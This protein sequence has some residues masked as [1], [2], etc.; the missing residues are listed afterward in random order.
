M[1]ACL[2]DSSALVACLLDEPGGNLEGGSLSQGA[3]ASTL[4]VQEL[5]SK[6]VRDGGT[7]DD[8]VATVVDLALEA[9]HA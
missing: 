2:A 1:A 6:I 4:Y 5:I 8:A 9:R 7:R 3:V